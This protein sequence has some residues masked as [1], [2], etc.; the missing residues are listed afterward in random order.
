[1]R[2]LFSSNVII[3]C[4][5]ETAGVLQANSAGWIEAIV[6]FLADEDDMELGIICPGS[7]EKK[8]KFRFGNYWI[9][10]SGGEESCYRRILSEFNPDILHIFG[11]ES[12]RILKLITLFGKPEKTII[13]LQGIAEKY[14]AVYLNDIPK[15]YSRGRVIET[16]LGHGLKKQRDSLLRRGKTERK[17]LE[18]VGHV[19]G[20]TDFDRMAVESVSQSIQYHFCWETLRSNFYQS[21]KWNVNKR[22]PF[23]IL[24][25]NT[26]SPIKGFHKMLEALPSIISRYPNTMLNVVGAQIRYPQ[27]IK[28][29]LV[30]HSYE[31]LCRSII[32]KNNL[33]DHIRF[34]GNLNEEEMIRAYLKSNV[35]VSASIIENSPNVICEAKILG[36]PIVSSFVGG[37]GNLIRHG[38]DGYL[39]DYYSADMLAYYVC[40]IFGNIE[41][42]QK[43]S[44]NAIESQKKIS[45]RQENK[46]RLLEI[47]KEIL[48]QSCLP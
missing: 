46:K 34:M 14:G 13:H 43:I 26:G 9:V 16:L 35:V 21:E 10:P 28:Q 36:V 39:Y 32:E 18:M 33:K 30:E 4:I 23:T 37:C 15:R 41:L 47:Y 12:E 48:D 7:T 3:P 38:H 24:T 40:K 44:L 19:T 22:V 5:A 42:A 2:V 8:G 1:M 6:S 17:A 45:D 20:R 27:T 25:R 29:H 11:S 31:A